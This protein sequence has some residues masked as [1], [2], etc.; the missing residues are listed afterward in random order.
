M[1]AWKAAMHGGGRRSRR[2]GGHGDDEEEEEYGDS[3]D[4]DHPLGAHGLGRVSPWQVGQPHLT[5]A[6]PL[7]A[8]VTRTLQGLIGA[9]T[10][11]LAKARHRKAAIL[12]LETE[13]WNEIASIVS[14]SVFPQAVRAAAS[15]TR[16]SVKSIG[17]AAG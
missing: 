13:L 11:R 4:P 15:S 17:A 2:S 12:G 14:R 8:A 16:R 1:K 6:S 10:V 9:A 7:E 3:T 5:I